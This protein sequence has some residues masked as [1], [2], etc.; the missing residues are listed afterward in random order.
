M[1]EYWN[2]GLKDKI[3][4]ELKL[5]NPLPSIPLFHYSILPLLPLTF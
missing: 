5:K 2:N 4:P 3:W 1:M